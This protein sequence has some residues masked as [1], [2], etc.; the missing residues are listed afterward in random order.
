MHNSRRML[1]RLVCGSV[2]LLIVLTLPDHAFGRK[3]DWQEGTLLKSE[4]LNP[5]Q[6]SSSDPKCALFDWWI[7]TVETENVIYKFFGS[8]FALHLVPDKNKVKFAI[9]KDGHVHILDEKGRVRESYLRL[10]EITSKE[11]G[12]LTPLPPKAKP[13][14][15]QIAKITRI[16]P[17][18]LL[19]NVPW[20]S[21][22]PP[23]P[24][25]LPPMP[26]MRGW[27]FELG[28]ADSSYTLVHQ[29]NSIIPLAVGDQTRIA[30]RGRNDA[31]II[32]EK[33]KE[34]KLNVSQRH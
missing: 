20:L 12:K 15:W 25:C 18:L 21:V 3:Y 23:P 27:A 7:H 30:E 19:I 33:G 29:G 14:N 26:L 24:P 5:N 11:A 28:T 16:K 13:R 8:A 2:F 17:I 34:W 4:P 22:S 32:D 9:E 10:Y 1:K 31:Y 6:P